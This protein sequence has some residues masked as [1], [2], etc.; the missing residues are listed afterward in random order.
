MKKTFAIAIIAVSIFS[1]VK[2]QED[3]NAQLNPLI[4]GVPFLTITPDARAGGM[5]DLGVATT[6][7][8]S[9]QYWNPAKYAFMESEVGL[10]FA[11]TPWLRRL[12][13]DISLSNLAAYWR[14]NERSTISGSFRY[15]SLGEVTL[16]DHNGDKMNDVKPSDFAIDAAYTLLFSEKLSGS[17]ALRF[18]RSNLGNIPSS[19][20]DLEPGLSFAADIAAYYTTPIM[21][22]TGDG[23]LAFGLNISNIGSK[24]SYDGN[25]TSNFIPTNFRLG[26]SFDYPIDSYNRIS[27]SADLNKLLVPSAPRSGSGNPNFSEDLQ[28]YYDTTPI[29]G[30]FKSFGDAP[31]GF[32]EELQE[33][34]WSAGLEYAYNKQFFVR[35]G[36]FHEHA[37]KGNRK[38]FTA[39]VGFKLNVFQLDAGYVMSVAQSN[40]LDGTLRL[41]LSFDLYGLKNLIN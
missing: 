10:T 30:I 16:T 3:V 41:G 20:Y 2:A 23:N 27:V 35:A 4:T 7:D 12:V 28:K 40:P 37:R 33:I 26:T 21:F 24:V 6:P 5:G 8:A 39:G 1:G 14:F 9:S 22:A 32:R 17:V 34:M 31:G 13:D 11:Y 29:A 38:F 19:G 15:F 18:I 36:Y 25:N